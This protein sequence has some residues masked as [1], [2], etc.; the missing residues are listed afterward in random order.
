MRFSEA[1]HMME[2]EHGNVNP[3]EI[4]TMTNSIAGDDSR[5]TLSA[6]PSIVWPLKPMTV[7]HSNDS[8]RTSEQRVGGGA[9][10]QRPDTSTVSSSTMHPPVPVDVTGAGGPL[11]ISESPLAVKATATGS[12]TSTLSSQSPPPVPTGDEH[13][14]SMTLNP[15]NYPFKS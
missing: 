7:E 13:T 11:T 10:M 2:C 1:L 9:D 5:S 14:A 8:F 12:T 4:L 3:N 6:L 15:R